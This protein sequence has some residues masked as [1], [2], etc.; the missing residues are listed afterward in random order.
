MKASTTLRQLWASRPPATW[1]DV[2][3]T[4]LL[5]LLAFLLFAYLPDLLYGALP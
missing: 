5:L 4:I 1:P 3:G 2:F